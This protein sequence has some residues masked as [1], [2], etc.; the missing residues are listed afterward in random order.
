MTRSRRWRTLLVW[1]I[2]AAT[3]PRPRA[4]GAGAGV[5][6]V[7]RRGPDLVQRGNDRHD[8]RG[9]ELHPDADWSPGQPPPTARSATS[10]SGS[11]SPTSRPNLMLRGPGV[12]LV[13]RT[14][15]VREWGISALVTVPVLRVGKKGAGF[16]LSAGPALGLWTITG[17]DS[18]TTIGGWRRSSSPRRFRRAG[19]CSPREGAPCRDHPSRRPNSPPSSSRPPSGADRSGSAC[20]TPSRL[21][22]S[23]RAPAPPPA[24]RAGGAPASRRPR[25]ARPPGP[26][27]SSGWPP[28]PTSRR[29]RTWRRPARAAWR[30]AG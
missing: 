1:T 28:P 10:G 22:T 20:S 25:P 7:G 29:S 14:L 13:D 12:E 27:S 15:D 21:R 6:G 19:G 30:P 9:P 24:P 5:A 11:G 2:V 17:L 4:R 18:R 8:E 23:G 16:S 26:G 3:S